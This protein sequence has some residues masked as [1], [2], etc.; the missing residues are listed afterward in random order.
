[1]VAKIGDRKSTRIRRFMKSVPIHAPGMD[2][3]NRHE[4]RR[5]NHLHLTLAGGEHE[6]EEAEV[7]VKVSQ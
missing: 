7:A 4:G 2:E 5:R 1:M 6:G 3:P